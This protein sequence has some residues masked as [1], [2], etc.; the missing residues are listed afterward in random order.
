MIITFISEGRE[1]VWFFFVGFLSLAYSLERR[2]LVIVR[3][4]SKRMYDWLNEWMSKWIDKWI[5]LLCVRYCVGFFILF[6]FMFR[7]DIWGGGNEEM[8]LEGWRCLFRIIWWS[9]CWN[10]GFFILCVVLRSRED[11]FGY[12]VFFFLN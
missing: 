4:M 12:W 9:G 11:F 8:S 2:Y 7:M 5:N 1:Y 3:R 6:F 10:L